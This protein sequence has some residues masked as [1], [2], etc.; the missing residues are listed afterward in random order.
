MTDDADKK[1]HNP[2]VNKFEE[3]DATT[4]ELMAVLAS[5]I[6]DTL[7]VNMRFALFLFQEVDETQDV[8]VFYCAS[9]TTAQLLPLIEVW[10]KRQVN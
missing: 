7:P 8:N 1:Q 3:R 5:K 10:M 6:Q 4:E 2:D 9:A